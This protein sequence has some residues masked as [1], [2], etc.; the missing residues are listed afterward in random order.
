[1]GNGGRVGGILGSEAVDYLCSKREIIRVTS[2]CD[3]SDDSG[4]GIENSSDY[5]SNSVIPA[6]VFR[7]ASSQKRSVDEPFA[8]SSKRHRADLKTHN[9]LEDSYSFPI[10]PITLSNSNSI[11]S[12]SS[13]DLQSTLPMAAKGMR[14]SV[15]SGKRLIGPPTLS[16]QLSSTSRNNKVQ[17]QILNQ[18]EQQHRA[19][20]QTEGSRGAVKDRTGNGFPVV[21]ITGY[22]KL[23]TLQ[24]FIGSDQ[25]RVTPH[26]FYQACRVTGKNSTPC[27]EKNINGTIVI[28]IDIDPAKDMTVTCD[29]VG[30][31]KERNVDV[32]HRFPEECSTR[33]KKKSTRC[34]MVFRA[35]ITNDDGTSETLQVASQPIAC[36]QPPGIPEICKKSLTSCPAAGGK[37]LFILGKNFLKDTHVMFQTEDWEQ[38]VNPDKEFLQQTHL[39]CTVPAFKNVEIKEPV[40]AKICVISGNRTSEPHSFTYTPLN[41][42]LSSSA[43]ST[44][45]ESSA[46]AANAEIASNAD[47]DADCSTPFAGKVHASWWEYTEAD[48][49]PVAPTFYQCSQKPFKPERCLPHF[50][51]TLSTLLPRSDS[52]IVSGACCGCG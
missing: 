16:S 30:I 18:P 21:K 15:V 4:I 7:F 49:T 3:N 13:Q 41:E 29:C 14:R 40:N 43:N 51:N 34:R 19:R 5:L 23:T 9:D 39:V 17:L 47:V 42:M 45:V 6:S 10:P 2:P 38:S 27:S 31:L 20:Y 52:M 1:M 33:S 12:V 22:N 35:V 48:N 11:C 8:L 46:R 24:V 37:E 36:T 25:G 50:S 32:E 28:E 44:A 26:M